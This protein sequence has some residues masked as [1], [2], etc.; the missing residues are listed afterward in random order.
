MYGISDTII[1]LCTKVK[2]VGW[3]L[4]LRNIYD[5]KQ[6]RVYLQCFTKFL[7]HKWSEGSNFD[8]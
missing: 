7:G 4:N 5:K 8:W 2:I 1:E 6:V 3:L